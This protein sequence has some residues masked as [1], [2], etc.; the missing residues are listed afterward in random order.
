M[1]RVRAGVDLPVQV[2][3]AEG[4]WYDTQRWPSFVDGFKAVAKAEG[5]W[6]KQ[7]S[8][9]LWDSVPAG[10]GRVVE[11]VTA[12]EV[13]A[14]Q[15]VAVEDAQMTGTQEVRFTPVGDRASRL[16]LDLRYKLKQQHLFTALVDLLFVRRAMS[17]AV[18]RSL[19]RFAREVRAEAEYG[20]AS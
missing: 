19:S 9:L 13:R 6:P 3:V 16:E 15:T 11:R 5:E 18:H 17:D 1:G 14:G 2:S 4:L 20:D 12:Y 10:R 7:G 8:R